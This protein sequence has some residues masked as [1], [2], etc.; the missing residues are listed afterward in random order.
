MFFYVY[1]HGVMIPLHALERVFVAV[2][3]YLLVRPV[4]LCV[5]F[6]TLCLGSCWV[7]VVCS[8]LLIPRLS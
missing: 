5:M 8:C 1:V 4:L 7:G 6:E 3:A 2:A